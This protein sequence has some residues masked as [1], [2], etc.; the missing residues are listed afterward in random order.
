MVE[1]GAELFHL[2]YLEKICHD[3]FN[4]FNVLVL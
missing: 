4:G 1:I 3:F 2:Y